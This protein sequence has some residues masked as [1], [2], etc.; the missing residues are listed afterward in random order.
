MKKTRQLTSWARRRLS[1]ANLMSTIAVFLTLGGATALAAHMQ[2]G[3][4]SVGSRQLK[5]QAVTTGKIR[6]NAVNGA[7]IATHSLTGEDINIGA[8][9]TVPNAGHADQADN[10][11]TVGN[12][13]A[14]CP[15]GTTLVRGICFDSSPGPEV[16]NVKAA[17]DACASKGGWL[18]TPMELYSVRSVINLGSGIGADH[19][20]TDSYYANTAGANY[21]TVVVDGSGAISEQSI[22]SPGHYVCAYPLVR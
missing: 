1:Y 13:G 2:L 4:N 3:K 7:K 8:L 5:S 14:A 21:R 17:A 19:Q 6:N 12:H 11:T 22:E 10:A 15:G 20:F 16:A 18:P 9:G